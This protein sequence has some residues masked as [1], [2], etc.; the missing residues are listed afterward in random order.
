MEQLASEL[1]LSTPGTE[2]HC[3]RTDL[4]DAKDREGLFKMLHAMALTPDLLINNAG[5]GDYGEFASADWRKIDDMMQVNMVALTH[6]THGLLPGMIA[7][8]DGQYGADI[9]NVSSLASILPIPDFSVYAATKAYVTS[10]SEALRLELKDYGIN[11]L[12][13]CPGPVHTEFGHVAQRGEH[14]NKTPGGEMVYVNSQQ[15]VSEGLAA[16]RCGKAR[17][18]PGLKIAI[19]AAAISLLPLA[20][21]RLVMG[22]RPRKGES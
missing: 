10:F 17:H 11:V 19:A 6:L 2:V 16:L 5:M 4:T 18:Y 15:V 1:S 8:A 21:I 12:A 14:S 9:L 22:R 3:I 20:A 13:L 7:E